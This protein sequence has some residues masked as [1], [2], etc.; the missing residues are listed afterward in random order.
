[1]EKIHEWI[2][3]NI[4]RNGIVIEAGVCFGEDTE[5]FSHH[6]SDGKVYG[7]EPIQHIFDVAYRRV[8]LRQNVELYNLGLSDKEGDFD[9]FYSDRFGQAWGSSSLRAPKEHLNFNPEITFKQKLP[10]KCINLDSW[11]DS[12]GIDRVDLLWLDLQGSEPD[13]LLASPRILSK[14]KYL[15]SEV[16]VVE[17]YDGQTVYSEYKDFLSKHGFKVVEEGL[18]WADGGNVLFENTNLI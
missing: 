2:V 3:A 11:A 1:M 13:V 8:G 6:L 12:K 9:M 17:N 18:Y 15:Y 14:T 4:P 16:S 5:R 10:V 7:F